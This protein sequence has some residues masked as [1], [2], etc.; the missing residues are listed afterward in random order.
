MSDLV[1]V[2]QSLGDI[3]ADIPKFSGAA[4]ICTF[5]QRSLVNQFFLLFNMKAESIYWVKE[6]TEIKPSMRTFLNI[7]IHDVD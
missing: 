3:T 4:V 1:A 7:Q 6:Q 5:Q 2:I